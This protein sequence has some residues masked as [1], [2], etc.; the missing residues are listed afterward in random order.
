MKIWETYMSSDLLTLMLPQDAQIMK[1]TP[2]GGGTLRITYLSEY[3]VHE[4][5]GKQPLMQVPVAVVPVGG[6]VP[7][8]LVP[9]CATALPIEP[10]RFLFV[11]NP[12]G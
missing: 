9:F 5:F 3:D 2:C 12:K 4:V 8:S 10:N 11:G 1:A 6:T 7:D